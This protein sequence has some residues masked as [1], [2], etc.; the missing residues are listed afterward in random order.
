MHVNL[1]LIFVSLSVLTSCSP[2][3]PNF[4]SQTQGPVKAA[5][6]EI[7]TLIAK[8]FGNLSELPPHVRSL[9]PLQ[10]LP[11]EELMWAL[12]QCRCMPEAQIAV[13][14][15]LAVAE[16]VLPQFLVPDIRKQIH[17]NGSLKK[18]L[19]LPG[20]LQKIAK[21]LFTND[22]AMMGM[23]RDAV[24]EKI[25]LSSK[26]Q[27]KND[28][29]FRFDN[30]IVRDPQS[31]AFSIQDMTGRWNFIMSM[32]NVW[33]EEEPLAY[34]NH[35]LQIL[36]TA[37]V[38]S[39]W[40]Y[41]FGIDPDQKGG[42]YGGLTFETN[43][44]KATDLIRLDP[45]D[46]PEARRTFSG[47]YRL[48]I[49][50]DVSSLDL[51]LKTNEKWTRSPDAPTILEQS[52]MWNAGALAFTRLRPD[53][54]APNVQLLFGVSDEY[55]LPPE[56]QLLPLIFMAGMQGLL[57]D[58]Y[59]DADL[60]AIQNKQ[61]RSEKVDLRVLARLG[62]SLFSWISVL[63]TL[64]K[65]GLKSSQVELLKEAPAL[66]TDGLRLVILVTLKDGLQLNAKGQSIADSA[67]GISM[68]VDI[69]Q[70]LLPSPLL[71]EQ[72]VEAFRKLVA[73]RIVPAWKGM[74][75]DP[76]TANDLVWFYTLAS[77]VSKY[78]ESVHKSPWLKEMLPTLEAALGKRGP[79]AWE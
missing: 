28:V 1:S 35:G 52:M 45:R 54:R 23:V 47:H 27:L 32:S 29:G 4:V 13:L 6:P 5:A 22:E 74:A 46:E 30:F 56:A 43:E 38:L 72:A 26:K 2:R 41:L 71:Q 55:L 59:L 73:T 44:P 65:A 64:E 39:E 40:K 50:Q 42:H 63:T 60:R 18:L 36:E 12:A 37:R 15:H 69:D 75:P 53:R 14:K 79:F 19:S 31:E 61:D 68:L 78:P 20:F 67:E 16:G 7:L 25:A 3:R 11:D 77:A 62:R 8:D 49:P 51:A 57:K 70:N 10:N 58:V 24:S 34:G 9:I 66:L 76:L 48:E 17:A 21:G 33:K